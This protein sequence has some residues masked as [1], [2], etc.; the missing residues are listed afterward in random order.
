MAVTI[1]LPGIAIGSTASFAVEAGAGILILGLI[2]A[3]GSIR[4][5]GVLKGG[6]C[7]ALLGVSMMHGGMTVADSDHDV[8]IITDRQDINA[9]GTI[10]MAEAMTKGRQ[11]IRF[12]PDNKIAGQEN[13]RGDWRLILPSRFVPVVPGDD[14]TLTAR[15]GPPLPQLL[16]GGFDFTN[17]AARRGFAATGFISAI[18]I[19]GHTEASPIAVLRYS[20]QSHLLTH[21]GPDEAAVAS[22]VLVG[23]RGLIPPDLREN[24]RASGLAHLL[25][26][27]GLHMALFCGGVV[28]LVR[29]V[30]ALMPDLSSR[31]AALKIAAAIALP[32][33]AAYLLLAG[34]PISAIRAFGMMVLL[35]IAILMDRR[36]LTL[37]HVALMALFLLIVDPAA[38]NDP[39]F[40]MS[41]AAVFALVAGWFLLQGLRLKHARFP[42]SS[43]LARMGRYIGGIMMASV[44]ASAASTPFVLHHFGV[45]TAWSVLANVIGMPLMALVVMP[46]GAMAL[47]LMPIGLEGFA[48]LPMELGLTALINLAG[49]IE[50]LPLS[51]LRVP[52]PSGIVLLLLTLSALLPFIV[53]GRY[54]MIS[55]FP[56]MVATIIWVFTPV[57]VASIISLHGRTHA[58]VMDA[59]G[60]GV[61]S[62][63]NR[64]ARSILQ[65]PFG[66]NSASLVDDSGH[67]C[68]RGY[69]L[70]TMKDNKHAAIVFARH[71][72]TP[73][74]RDAALVIAFVDA[75]YPCRGGAVLI[76][77]HY[78]ATHG[79]VLIFNRSGKLMVESVNKRG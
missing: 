34:M 69:C 27:S 65:R 43:P 8:L 22:A 79:G 47:L 26:I 29:A 55:V 30:M 56:L 32:T 41:F 61:A 67:I 1:M 15:I 60:K 35:I 23:L 70:I 63:E 17:H 48:L 72:M 45:T 71:A 42:S 10:T 59:D 20:V 4:F 25:A 5:H 44:L 7:L 64:F 49:L 58:M 18:T 73:A 36:G 78:L 21:L 11:R 50:G 40:Q 9:S 62:S 74:C 19:T 14:V 77:R 3:F 52:P 16:P 54:V 38:I 51:A 24:F 31:Y 68:H 76:D 57:P 37:H 66:V 6:L 46:S 13:F 2:M 33:G 12:R 28:F 39:A 53:P 75:L